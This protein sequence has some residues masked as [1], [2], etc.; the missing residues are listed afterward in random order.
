MTALRGV[1]LVTLDACER[2]QHETRRLLDA[3]ANRIVAVRTRRQEAGQ[4]RLGR[5]WHSPPH[6]GLLLSIGMRGD[7]HVD[8]LDGFVRDVVDA[9]HD[10]LCALARIDH[11]SIAWSAPNDLVDAATGD[12]LAGVLVDATSVGCDVQQLLVGI[13]V[14]VL[15]PAFELPDEARRVATLQSVARRVLEI[16]DAR[17]DALARRLAV[18]VATRAGVTPQATP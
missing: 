3:D 14:N 7:M 17:F 1:T 18:R 11:A 16:D 15:G 10:E 2:A 5:R 12:K 9:V 8:V 4:G 13:G 6:P